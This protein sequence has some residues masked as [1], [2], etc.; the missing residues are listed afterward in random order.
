MST[1]SRCFVGSN[2]GESQ[3]HERALR[4]GAGV[5]TPLSL[6]ADAV[7]AAT[8]PRVWSHRSERYS[9]AVTGRPEWRDAA[10]AERARTAGHAA[11]VEAAVERHGSRWIEHLLGAFAVAIVDRRERRIELLVD[12]I[13]I[14]PL[15]YYANGGTFA[16]A[17]DAEV[18]RSHP[19]VSTGIDPQAVFDYLFFHV[20]PAPDS[21]WRDVFKVL[22]AHRVVWSADAGVSTEQYWRPSFGA[23]PDDPEARKRLL[24][25]TREAVAKAVGGDAVGAYLSGGLDSSTVAGMLHEHRPGA[26]AFS[27]G[28][29]VEGYDEMSYARTAAR[30]F[31]LR[32]EE[33]YVKPEDV[34]DAIPA[35]AAAYDEPYGNSSAVP[36]YYCA[37]LARSCGVEMLLA[38]DGGDE[39]FAG[40]VRYASQ[41]LF[42]PYHRL[43]R[44]LRAAVIEPLLLG[45]LSQTGFAP[46]RKARSYVQQAKLPMPERMLTYNHVYRTGAAMLADEF[47]RNV[48][49]DRPLE[50]TRD[51]YTAAGDVGMLNSML[52]HDWRMTLSDND[53][54]KVQRTC[55]MAGVDV[56]FPLLDHALI[57][58]AAELSPRA[59]L[60]GMRLRHFYRNAM[61]GYLPYEVIEKKKHGF[62]LPIGV[63]MRDDPRLRAICDDA[64]AKF[65][66]RGILKPAYLEDLQR[67]HREEHAHYYGEF[68]WVVMALELWLEARGI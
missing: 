68:L 2:A 61:R 13:G 52:V 24:E 35:I 46:V 51:A 5:T 26:P 15:Y 56:A 6:P 28:F 41:K 38:G 16:F 53:L 37:K 65:G 50:L 67:L 33:Y 63:W 43:P 64:I 1:I 29:D 27:V 57:E 48:D 39:L 49:L 62:G 3:D 7:F 18:L 40:N 4:E 8:G 45:P 54:R 36:A 66:E 32:H 9:V 25:D 55:A 22:P 20:V 21:I 58:L 30:H 23:R 14:E 44:S 11:A 31:G 19:Q 59:K 47:A 34:A 12:R 10:L 60:P 17:T 42:E